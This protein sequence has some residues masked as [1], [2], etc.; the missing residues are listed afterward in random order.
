MHL[1]FKFCL[2]VAVLLT[3]SF[4]PA[5]AEI[6]YIE[7][8]DGRFSVSFPDLWRITSNMKPDDQLTVMGPGKN[9]LAMCRVRVREEGRFKIY[10]QTI[11]MS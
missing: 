2:T 8:Q 4:S 5:K 3:F 1:I 10:P 7:D 6:F 11:L 9:D